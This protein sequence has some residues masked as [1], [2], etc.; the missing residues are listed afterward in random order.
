VGAALL[1]L[2]AL[3]QSFGAAAQTNVSGPI[4]SS[5][6]WSTANSP[7][8]VTGNVDILSN[9]TLTIQPGVTVYV[10]AGVAVSVQNG[11]L[12]ALGTIASPIVFTSDAVRTGGAGAPGQWGRLTFN[13]GAGASR[14]ENVVVEYGQGVVVS[15]SSPTFNFV[16]IRNNAGPAIAID[17]ASSPSGVGNR[18]SGNTLNA[19]TVPA[20]DI[21]GNV[22]WALRGIP[23]LVANGKVSVGQSPAIASVT[24]AAIEQ[25]ETVVVTVTGDR[26][27]NATSV[28]FENPGLS[29]QILGNGASQMQLSVTA[30]A[31]ATLGGN[32]LRLLVDAGEV[33]R[34][35]ALTVTGPQFR[36]NSISPSTVYVNQGAVQLQ[37]T[38]TQFTTDAVA[39]VNGVAVPTT[40]VSSTRIDASLANQVTGGVSA[41]R[42]RMPDPL[43]AGAFVFSGELSLTVLTPAL[44]LTPAQMTLVSGTTQNLTL[45]LPYAAPAGGQLI[46]LVSSI[47]IVATVPPNVT[48][49]E[50]QLTAL[51]PVTGSM[52]DATTI[53][54]SRAG[55]TSAQSRVTVVPPPTLS[56]A[57][58]TLTVGVGRTSQ[59]TITSSAAAPAGGVTINLSSSSP[60]F[61]TVPPTVTLPAGQTT[62]NTTL[63]TVGVG[64]TTISAQA[65]GY[66]TGTSQI[67]VRPVSINFGS[68]AVV[69]PGLS[70]NV[71]AT[72]SDPAPAGGLVISLSS[73]NPAV[74]TVP[75]SVTVPEGHTLLSIPVTGVAP[76]TATVTAT[77]TGYQDGTI[78]INVEAITMTLTGPSGSIPA[79]MTHVFTLSLS[80]PAPAGGISV[81]LAAANPA[82]VTVSPAQIDIPEGQTSGGVV[83]VN[84]TGV[85]IGTTQ[86]VMSAAGLPN[87][88]YN[89]N[90]T[91]QPTIT[92]S[93][94]TLT[95]GRGLRNYEFEVYAYLRTGAASYSPP[96]GAT[97]TLT[98]SDPTRVS[99]PATFDIAANN[100]SAYFR[101][102]GV[103]LTSG[104]PVTVTASSPGY[105]TQATPATVNV[106][107]P[108]M[109]FSGFNATRAVGGARESF[110]VR[111]TVPGAD[112]PN[113]QTPVTTALVDLSFIDMSPPGIVDGIY[114]AATGGTPAIMQ[115]SIAAGSTTTFTRYVG[116][117][118]GAGTYRLQAS[119]AALGAVGTSGLITVQTPALRFSDTSI[120]VGRGLQNY[121]FEVYVYRVV[122]NT[123]V[124]SPTATTVSLTSS[125]PSRVTVP[126]TVTIPAND[127]SQYFVI[128]GVANT[129]SPVTITASAP[130]HDPTTI[131]VNVNVVTPTLLFPS[132]DNPRSAASARDNFNVRLNV[133]GADNPQNQ[134]LVAPLTVDLA[135]AEANP[136]DIVDGFYSA[137]TGGSLITQTTIAAGSTN[138]PTI[139]VNTPTAGG[140]Y[141][142]QGNAPTLGASGLSAA[143][144]VVL[145]ELRFSDTSITV[146]RGLQNYQF[147]VYVYRA[148]NGSSFTAPTPL[149]VNL[150]SSDPSRVSVP[151]TVTIPANDASQYFTVTGVDLTSGTPVTITASAAGFNNSVTP[152][153]A[154][155]IVPQYQVINLE[156]PRSPASPRDAFN[157]RLSVPGADNPN[158]QTPATAL[159]ADLSIV[160]GIPDGIV[161]GFFS[162]AT[163]G[164]SVSQATIAVGSNQS[165][166]LY[167]ETPTTAGSYRVRAES[168]ATGIVGT[169]GT[170]T[171]IPPE[172]RFS[173][174]TLTVG[175][176][177]RNYQ[178]EVYVYRAVSGSSYSSPQPLTVNLVCNST[179]VCTVPATVTI[180]A[181]D[182]GA[183]FV[184]TGIGLG[185][186]T[187]TATAPGY[188]SVQDA[189]VN[190]VV[191]NLRFDTIPSSIARGA[192]GTMR[193]GVS[194][195]GADNPNNQTV[196]VPLTISVTSSAPDVATVPATVTVAAGATNSPN[197]QIAGVAAGTTTIT[198]SSPD[199]NPTS[200]NVT[201]NP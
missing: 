22:T 85:A 109:S 90:I 181:N 147:E 155:V 51:V 4:N 59:L 192:N 72:L 2:W 138:S 142:V 26:L 167:V 20:G 200:T 17:L 76:G 62:V 139:Y 14:L 36:L 187:I 60:T 40:F 169:S 174:T 82:L 98:S 34:A 137:L 126:A 27:Q 45:T 16:D 115:L 48:V 86:V 79:S 143:T 108:Q 149:T 168:A 119:N 96:A 74:L 125:D 64:N 69:A 100:N 180:P 178:F 157:V 52:F 161:T 166:T 117:P 5:T 140:S 32:A 18:A 41:V 66:V 80:R 191:P 1:G 163:G 113:N 195:P 31:D 199:F 61:A 136:V 83:K 114:T 53:T 93:D 77:A 73:S 106:V 81:S 193:V 112:N 190:V 124:T 198:A 70:R 131:P 47:P 122:G 123:S 104:T 37:L 111:F 44:T 68:G 8:V 146:G 162:A 63:T 49:P 160:E 201:V 173:D 103:E 55:F 78:P 6:T 23:Y 87:G 95:V 196:V 144:T 182:T 158:N 197:A 94:T 33:R 129:D 9:A 127:S 133:P 183:Y 91:A 50:G 130:G 185:S 58:D 194:T 39:F 151:A 170:V 56:I 28:T 3:A 97:I 165:P 65:T 88:T 38:G 120:T 186:T 134:T 92:F 177:L 164:N 99:V 57:P 135:I 107:A 102:A 121:Q 156:N 24:P 153:S 43:N 171:V 10:Q 189:N 15:G 19:I 145:P 116:S 75:A 89:A 132:L 13:S 118:T 154:N 179:A 110:T 21:T 42:V 29:A 30:A 188:N 128:T 12:S 101:V 141:R 11:A 7:Y 84:L 25:G 54:A 148:I 184:V 67:S 35:A 150:T 46:N 159:S 71:P 152:I 172:L 176:G 175:R 105:A